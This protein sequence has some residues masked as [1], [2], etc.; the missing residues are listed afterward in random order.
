MNIK[1]RE[2]QTADPT[3]MPCT[4]MNALVLQNL[5]LFRGGGCRTDTMKTLYHIIIYYSI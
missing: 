5:A 4:Y 2:Y 3:L 1:I